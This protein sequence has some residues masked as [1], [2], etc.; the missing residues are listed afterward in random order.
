MMT[1]RDGTHADPG[2]KR[3]I[4]ILALLLVAILV[5]VIAFLFSGQGAQDPPKNIPKLKEKGGAV[6]VEET[7]KIEIENE[8]KNKKIEKFLSKGERAL[9]LARIL[10]KMEK[11]KERN[12]VEIASIN[13]DSSDKEVLEY[14]RE[15]YMQIRPLLKECYRKHIEDVAEVSGSITMVFTIISDEEYGGLIESSAVVGESEIAI[16][17]GL[18]E[19]LR[20]SMYAMKLPALSGVKK[21]KIEMPM[22]FA[23]PS[24]IQKIKSQERRAPKIVMFEYE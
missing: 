14:V 12:R 13:P 3:T 17:K 15:P 16:S 21:I 2:K 22:T 5:V 19:C 24:T 18:N 9:A 7:P 1:L 6:L 8:T 23:T 11:N 20:E 4:T 10:A